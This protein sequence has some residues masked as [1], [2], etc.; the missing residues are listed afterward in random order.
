V[1]TRAPAFNGPQILDVDMH[2]G[3]CQVGLH[4]AI[5]HFDHVHAF[6]VLGQVE[7]VERGVRA[8]LALKLRLRSHFLEFA[9]DERAVLHV[10]LEG[11][12]GF[13]FVKYDERVDIVLW[14]ECGYVSAH[15]GQAVGSRTTVRAQVRL[16]AMTN[17][18]QS[19][20]RLRELW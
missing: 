7:L 11:R 17:L 12:L 8:Q 16:P 4:I 3:S 6:D 20:R 2:W 5:E 9:I 18:L 1:S 13:I 10:V 19:N 14:M 15:V